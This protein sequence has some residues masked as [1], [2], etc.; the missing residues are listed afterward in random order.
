M[1]TNIFKAFESKQDDL[2]EEGGMIKVRYLDY[3]NFPHFK[4]DLEDQT[5]LDHIDFAHF[6]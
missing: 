2:E 3:F 6:N 1:N 4:I 5:N